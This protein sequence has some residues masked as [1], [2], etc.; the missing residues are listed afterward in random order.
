MRVPML[1][2]LAGLSVPLVAVAQAGD[3]IAAAQARKAEA[4]AE[5]AASNAEKAKWEAAAAAEKAKLG[6]LGAKAVDGSVEVAKD[7]GKFESTFLASKSVEELAR[8]VVDGAKGIKATGGKPRVLIVTGT[9]APGFEAY[10]AFTL[11]VQQLALEFDKAKATSRIPKPKKT[12]EGTTGGAASLGI[13]TS[14]AAVALDVIGNLFRA[15]YKVA[16]LEF[17]LDDQLLVR[18]I[19]HQAHDD[20]EIRVPAYSP[21]AL[22][23]TNPAVEQFNRVL[24]D[25]TAAR[26]LLAEAK[27]EAG[28][29]KNFD[30]TD[31]IAALEGYVKSA[32]GFIAE[33]RTAVAGVVPFLQIAKQAELLT[34]LDGGFLLTVKVHAAGGSSVAKKN[35][36]TFLGAMPFKVSGGALVSYSVFDGKTGQV[37]GGGVFQH[38]Q[39]LTPLT[40]ISTK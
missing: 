35:F 13:A 29:N 12:R 6:P 5:A 28:K 30:Y 33:M 17:T 21:P 8:K 25:R 15:D 7:A 19:I 31:R 26:L 20:W 2:L 24:D 14:S 37:V 22:G 23:M 9:E 39:T 11:R 16:P 27:A 36:W 38:L 32:E 1:M 34:L 3:P 18:A 4:E 40:R 10:D